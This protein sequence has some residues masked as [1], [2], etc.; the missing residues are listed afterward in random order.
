M[1]DGVGGMKKFEVERERLFYRREHS[2]YRQDSRLK[3]L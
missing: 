1:R 3:R 2:N